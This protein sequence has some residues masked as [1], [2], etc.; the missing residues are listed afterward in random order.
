[1][2]RFLNRIKGYCQSGMMPFLGLGISVQAP[3]NLM[4]GLLML[5]L[6][7]SGVDLQKIGLFA[8]V[9]LPYSLKFLWAPLIDRLQLPGSQRFGHKKTWCLLFQIGILVGLICLSFL[10]PQTQT[11]PLFGVCLFIAVC[12]ASQ[13]LTVDAL[14]IDTLSGERLNQGTVLFQFGTRLGYFAAT[15]GMIA[16]SGLISWH[17]VYRLSMVMIGTGIISLICLHEPRTKQI[18]ATFKTMVIIPFRDLMQ[19][20]NMLWLCTFIILYKMCNGMLGKMAYP[21]YADIGF[22]KSQ[23]A[24]V[25]ATFG[26]LITTIGICMGG[27]V[28]G[29]FRFKPLLMTLGLI[30]I[31]TSMAFAGLAIAGPSIPL[32]MMVIVFDNIVGGIGGAVWSVFLSRMC[33]RDFSA[34]QYGFLNALTMVPLTLL[35]AGSGWLAHLC[36]WPVYF[37]LTGIMMVPA[38]FMLCYARLAPDQTQKSESTV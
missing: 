2:A 20:Q 24:T 30:E 32:F 29:R 17:W 11:I 7:D 31:L 5:W 10:N 35:G 36:G 37:A 28:L 13:E 21:F 1:M 3:I 14:R 16:L 9:T 33:S 27:L 26:S 4:G 38:L 12:G 23:I 34:T 22:T 6:K 19:R 25:S 15:A 18:P 8:M